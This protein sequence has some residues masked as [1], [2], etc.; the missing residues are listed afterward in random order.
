MGRLFIHLCE[1]LFFYWQKCAHIQSSHGSPMG[2]FV[3][4]QVD[5]FT[6]LFFAHKNQVIFKQEFPNQFN[7]TE[8]FLIF[9]M[10]I[11][12][13]TPNC[14]KSILKETT[15]PIVKHT[16]YLFI[17]FSVVSKNHKKQLGQKLTAPLTPNDSSKAGFQPP[18]SGFLRFG[19]SV[20]G[21]LLHLLALPRRSRWF[22]R[23]ERKTGPHDSGQKKV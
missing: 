3:G 19:A 10:C 13:Y 1:W 5:Y 17:S 18:V 2:L 4:F 16:T 11:Q 14:V 6:N 8:T 12:M 15:K 23:F 20:R 22:N 9:Q 21:D 7:I